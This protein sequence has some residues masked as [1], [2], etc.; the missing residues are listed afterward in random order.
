MP[1]VV[2]VP[3]SYTQLNQQQA[4]GSK[5]THTRARARTH[6][7]ALRCR[8]GFRP[9]DQPFYRLG[10]PVGCAIGAAEKSLTACT[11]RNIGNMYQ[12][13]VFINNHIDII[14][15]YHEA[16]E[17]EVRRTLQ[18]DRQCVCVR[19]VCVCVSLSL[20]PD[21]PP[22]L[23]L[24]LSLSLPVHIHHHMQQAS[25]Q[26]NKQTCGFVVFRVRAWLA[27]RCSRAASSTSRAQTSTAVQTDPLNPSPSSHQRQRV[28]TRKMSQSQTHSSLHTPMAS[29]SRRA[30]R[31]LLEPSAASTSTSTPCLLSLQHTL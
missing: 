19:V 21:P 15:R 4:T 2:V 3:P 14:I 11:M 28:T 6:A 13:E 10:F 30:V 31:V 17:F 25:K 26:T 16:P 22:P 27:L 7:P 29:T 24:S 9:E 20:S 1:V 5:H 23:S 12:N 8:G 18:I